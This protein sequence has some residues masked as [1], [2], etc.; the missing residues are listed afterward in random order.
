MTFLEH[1]WEHWFKTENGRL[2]DFQVQFALFP[3]SLEIY[4]K[5]NEFQIYVKNFFE[6]IISEIISL[7][8]S[9]GP[10]EPFLE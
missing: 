7:T 4:E 5:K 10:A 1:T 8:R 2:Q 3:T 6:K 9:S